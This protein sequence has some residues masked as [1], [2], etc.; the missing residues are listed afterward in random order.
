MSSTKFTAPNCRILT[1]VGVAVLCIASFASSCTP[2]GKSPPDTRR[3]EDPLRTEFVRYLR[4]TRLSIPSIE[5][6]ERVASFD[7]GRQIIVYCA[8]SFETITPTS[9]VRW[10]HELLLFNQGQLIGWC[11]IG[12]SPQSVSWRGDILDVQYDSSGQHEL[13]S[14]SCDRVDNSIARSFIPAD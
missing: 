6:F 8:D 10:N 14:P 9:D 13:I 4:R 3:A 5:R 2:S 12:T 7:H 11:T 1:L